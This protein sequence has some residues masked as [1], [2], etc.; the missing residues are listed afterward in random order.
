MTESSS[1]LACARS[2]DGLQKDS[3]RPDQ[4]CNGAGK[5]FNQNKW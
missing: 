1:C 3:D 4:L 5:E 2:N